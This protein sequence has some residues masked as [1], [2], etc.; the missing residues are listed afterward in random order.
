MS[1]ITDLAFRLIA[2]SFECS[3][4]YVPLVS[5]K[6]LVLGNQKTYDLLQTD[7][8]EK[9]VGIQIFGG[10]PDVIAEASARLQSIPFDFVDINMGCPA[11]KI[12]D[13]AGGCSLLRDPKLAA[14][15]VRAAVKEAGKPVTAK[16]RS[17]WDERSVNAVQLAQTLQDAGASAIELHP[18]TKT[19]R[20]T[21]RADWDLIARVKQAVTI[22]V[23]GN[24]DVSS[25]ED[26]KRMLEHT[27]CD[28]VMI[29]RAARGNPWIF[30]RSNFLLQ[31]GALPPEPTPHEKIHTLINHCT[32]LA[33]YEGERRAAL[34]MRK[35]AGWYIR[36]LQ[37]AA[38]ARESINKA[39]TT[40]EIVQICHE[41]EQ[42]WHGSCSP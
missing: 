37:N 26:V 17:G 24:G 23:I 42:R 31:H 5:A 22:P 27:Q 12:A 34:K 4:L 15:V 30:R 8:A 32:I 21:G 25:P 14:A 28:L 7:P 19:Q 36:G 11:P 1:G 3:L 10:D 6:A 39:Q 9:P 16:I 29:A 38:S 33:A 20:F 13:H 2:K 18:R 41:M 35:H 40:A